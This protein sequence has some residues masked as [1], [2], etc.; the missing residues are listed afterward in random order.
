[1]TSIAKLVLI[2]LFSFTTGL[3]SSY[4]RWFIIIP[5]DAISVKRGRLAMALGKITKNGSVKSDEK[6]EKAMVVVMDTAKSMICQGPVPMPCTYKELKD[7]A[8]EQAAGEVNSVAIESA[9]WYL[10]LKGDLLEHKPGELT[11]VCPI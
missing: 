4:Q 3:C 7:R 10:R 5:V 11:M 6:V 1:L 8:Y 2:D 9:I